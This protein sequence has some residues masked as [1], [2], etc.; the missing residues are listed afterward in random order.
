MSINTSNVSIQSLCNQLESESQDYL[1]LRKN[2]VRSM[3]RLRAT[4]IS[5]KLLFPFIEKHIQGIDAVYV[6]D[7][8]STDWLSSA[9]VSVQ[10]DSEKIIEVVSHVK[11]S[12]GQKVGKG[13]IEEL[14]TQL[15]VYLKD[16]FNNMR[17]L[18]QSIYYR[19]R[20]INAILN[21]INSQKVISTETK[22]FN[23]QSTKEFFERIKELYLKEGKGPKHTKNSYLNEFFSFLYDIHPQSISLEEQ[24]SV[25]SLDNKFTQNLSNFADLARDNT[26]IESAFQELVSLLPTENNFDVSP[27]QNQNM[28]ENLSNRTATEI[29]LSAKKGEGF[30][31]SYSPRSILFVNLDEIA[32]S[33]LLKSIETEELPDIEINIQTEP[34]AS[35]TIKCGEDTTS[36][37]LRALR[38]AL[39]GSIPPAI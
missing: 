3:A 23:E 39:T 8:L 14:V 7:Q 18:R 21:Y 12:I 2:Q 29:S 30:H 20:S 27:T 28:P 33:L 19:S 24:S 9:M 35:L 17:S 1:K 5:Q 25:K 15:I 36:S 34:F 13:S 31:L 6:K 26:N 10:P 16:D 4:T 11:S 38:N 37:Q 22:L 32:D